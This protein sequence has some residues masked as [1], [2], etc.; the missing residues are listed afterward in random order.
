MTDAETQLKSFVDKFDPAHRTI[1]RAVRK[2]LRTR[3]PTAIELAY[4][5]YNFF[6]IGY[7]PTE[8]PSDAIVSIAAGASGVGLCFIHGARLADPKKI[9]LGSGKQTRF[10]RI[11]S[12][13]VLQ[14]PEVD[15]L[16]T[17]AV[18]GAKT[19]FQASGRGTLLI[20]SVSAK[21]RPRRSHSAQE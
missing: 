7:S 8:R 1:I 10:I 16:L 4:D 5:N 12:A 6:V 11:E 15:T 19:P 18:A 17:A 14:R 3:F 20:R 2:A 9:L 21:Q 13:A